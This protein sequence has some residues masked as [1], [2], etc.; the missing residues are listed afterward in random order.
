MRLSFGEFVLNL[1][2]RQV[3]RANDAIALSPKA[4]QLLEM[5]VLRRPDALSKDE[6]QKAIWPEAFVGDT[7]LA[8]LVNELR[9]AFG[10]E[11]RESR[12]I[13]TV[14]RF[15][16]AFQANARALPT[17]AAGGSAAPGCRLLW[18][19]QEIALGEGENMIGRDPAASVCIDDV[20]VSR[21]HARILIDGSAV[22]IEDLGSK[23]GTYVR[24]SRVAGA[25]PLRDGDSVRLG[26]VVV[27]FHRPETGAPT[28]TASRS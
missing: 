27:V 25:A 12:V 26:S 1:G 18:G 11:S 13:R 19:E 8:N 23:N 10:D 28:E 21:Y 7:S 22:R 17:P 24:E 5:L 16:Y 14:H 4:F 15:G 6:L 2:T 20:S 9:T 3:F